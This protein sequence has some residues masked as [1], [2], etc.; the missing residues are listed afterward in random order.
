L[1]LLIAILV[2]YLLGSVPW[3]WAL[4]HWGRGIDIRTY[5]SGNMGAANVGRALGFKW[6]LAVA[7]LD[8]AKGTVAGVAGLVL[9]GDL[10]GVLAGA[11]AMIG[12]CRPLYLGFARGGK[13]VATGVGVGLAIAPLASLLTAAIWVVTFVVTRYSSVASLAGAVSIPILAALLGA[14]ATVLGFLVPASLVVIFLH[15]ANI[16]RLLAG[17]ENRFTFSRRPRLRREAS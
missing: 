4:P 3:G 1:T 16:R 15:R 11:G 10:G 17:T 2:G 6:G 9:A 7:L 13:A 12:H 8:I 14:S 5:G